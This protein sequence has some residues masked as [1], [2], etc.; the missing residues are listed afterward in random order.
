MSALMT[1]RLTRVALAPVL[2]TLAA[3]ASDQ[4][5]HWSYS[6]ADGPAHWGGTCSTGKS[7]SPIAIDSA[8][9][10]SEKLPPLMIDYRPGPLHV[11]DNG[12]TIQVNVEP[13]S[14]ISVG[15]TKY[16]LIQF[17]FHKPSEEVID[18]RQFAMVAHLVHKDAAGNLAVIAVPLKAGAEN[19]AIAT[20]WRH[21]PKEKGHEESLHGVTISPGQ[22]L[23]ANRAYFTYTGSLTTPPCTE[24]VRWFVLKSPNTASLGE[25][26]TFA[27][28]YSMNARPT[29]P[30]NGRQ[31]LAS[32]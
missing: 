16:A 6:G 4:G 26:T 21:L 23:P 7:Q 1:A 15:G 32:K 14:T 10:K 11:I 28:L 2:L 30:L 27:R 29:E 12:H 8:S 9:A 20:V 13:G 5:H 19:P 24:G 31:V 18:G 17:H 22:L 3:A 25:I